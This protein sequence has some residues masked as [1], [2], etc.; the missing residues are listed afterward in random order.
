MN[1]NDGQRNL[2]LGSEWIF[3]LNTR[4]SLSLVLAKAVLNDNGPAVTGLSIKYEYFWGK[5]YR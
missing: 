2:I 5:G 3:S 4:N 1:Q